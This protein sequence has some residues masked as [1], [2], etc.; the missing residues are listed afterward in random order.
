MILKQ[1]TPSLLAPYRVLD[2]TEGGCLIGGKTLADLGADVIKIEPPGGSPSRWIGP[3]HGRVPDPEKS[4]F[5]FAYNTNKRSLSLDIETPEGRDIFRKLVKTSDFILESFRPG[6]M[7]ELGLGYQSLSEINPRLIMSSIT[8]FGQTGPYAQYKSAEL[9]NWAMG[10]FLGTTGVPER[11]PVW[12]GFPQASLHAGNYAAVASMIAHVYRESSGKGQHIDVSTQQCVILLLYGAPRWWEFRKVERYSPRTGSYLPFTKAKPGTKLIYPCKDGEVFILLMG[13][14]GKVM[15]TSSQQLVAYMDEHNMASDRLKHFNWISEFNALTVTQ[16]VIDRIIEEVGR[17]FLTKT[18]KELYEQAIK[19]RILL[20][21][22]ADA[23]DV[24]ENIQLQA[25]NFWKKTIHPKL[26]DTAC[27]CGP[28][29]QL[30][31]APIRIRR[32]SPLIGEHNEEILKA[33]EAPERKTTSVKNGK[34]IPS[35]SETT[36]QKPDSPQQALD[37]IKV[38]DFSWSIVGPLTVKHLADHGAT[39]V[40][41]ESHTRPETNRLGGPYKDDISGIDRSSLYSLYNTSKYGMSLNMTHKRSREVARRLMLWADVVLESFTPGVM[42]KYDLDYDTIK[43]EKPDIIYVSTSCYGQ[44]G[45]IAKNPGYGQ[46]ATAQCG[47]SHSVGWPDLPSMA[48]S[49]PHTDFISPTFL[50]TTIL[51][52]LDYKGRT[53]RGLHIDQS[54]VEA[55]VHFF[56]PPAIDYMMNQRILSRDGNHHPHASPHNVYPCLGEDKWCAI[57]VFT[58]KEWQNFLEAIESPGWA[59]SDRFATLYKRKEN[60]EE[61]DR[62]IG[63][64]TARY[65]PK[66]VMNRMQN[67]GVA[68]GMVKTMKDICEDPQLAHLGFFRYLEHPILGKH[69]HQGPPFRL[70]LSPDRQ[71]TSPCLGQHNAYVYKEFLKYSDDEIAE[72]LIEGVI[73]TEADL[74][75][76]KASF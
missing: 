47:I 5:W 39:V 64:W 10:G 19:R 44:Y 1:E 22:I 3:F 56:A 20:A 62:L 61:L 29:V 33:L 66:E 48:G 74:P 51:A 57:A 21:P 59:T 49:T 41:V 71:F 2:L 32:R 63:A 15:Y 11:P 30:S 67:H 43:K 37:G 6:Y 36:E 25:R 75:D 28:F 4:L 31:E 65:T 12:V 8:P 52:A 26:G 60:E 42:K 35:H 45:P 24:C 16:D 18:K 50:T 72:M 7:D 38:V 55:G 9:V 34:A 68:A 23:K 76:F 58:E 40:R 69:A 27:L 54:Q 70:S 53:G 14:G 73:T 17:F 13:G 46:L